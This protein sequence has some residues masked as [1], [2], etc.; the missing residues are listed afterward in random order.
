M[1][2]APPGPEADRD[3][4]P[5]LWALVSDIAERLGVPPPDGIFLIADV[6]A[7]V[8][9]NKRL[10]RSTQLR[11][12]LGMGILHL[13]TRPQLAAVLAH[14][15][16]HLHN[17][18]ADT[19]P[20]R[21]VARDLFSLTAQGLAG[22]TLGDLA[23]K[24]LHATQGKTREA[25]HAADAEAVRLV[26]RE[27]YTEALVRSS[28]GTSLFELFVHQDVAPLLEIGWVPD[29]L[30]DGFVPFIDA[31]APIQGAG[32]SATLAA[33]ATQLGDSHPA[34][35]DRLAHLRTVDEPADPLV[36]DDGPAIE[37]IADR[38]ALEREAT[39]AW[40]GRLPVMGAL[41]PVAWADVAEQVLAPW[42]VERAGMIAA[43]AQAAPLPALRTLLA[44]LD[45][46]APAALAREL[47]PA[48]ATVDDETAAQL[49]AVFLGHLLAGVLLS[50]GG[51]MVYAPGTPAAV[52]REGERLETGTLAAAAVADADARAALLETL[53]EDDG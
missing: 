26:G 42:M 33:A 32:L 6:N 47:E 37:L 23:L 14:E 36:F 38:E 22:S 3:A 45:E 2:G 13:L 1:A 12:L 25:E 9:Q 17:G 4:Q 11:L 7:Y 44:R 50:H 40:A 43:R 8:I 27:L 18:D 15:L 31:S 19:A 46:T 28:L 41:K 21:N 5:A 52:V 53:P 20:M 51:T 34:L 30:F 24:G 29:N 16:A 49:F 35:M 48:L 10:F 39:E